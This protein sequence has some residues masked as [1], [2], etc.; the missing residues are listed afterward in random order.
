MPIDV[1]RL[2]T[3]YHSWVGNALR[4]RRYDTE[5]IDDLTHARVNFDDMARFYH[6]SIEKW[7][8]PGRR[9]GREEQLD[10]MRLGEAYC[11]NVVTTID[12]VVS[13]LKGFK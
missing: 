1:S 5:L 4:N 6:R 13:T 2:P 11:E 10:S 7:D 12:E 9:E 3:F 8:V